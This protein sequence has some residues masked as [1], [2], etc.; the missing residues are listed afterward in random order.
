MRKAGIKMRR[1]KC[2]FFEEKIEHFGHVVNEQ[3][4]RPNSK[5]ADAIRTA[6][7]PVD[8]QLLE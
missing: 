6:F 7:A 8:K 4:V 1:N 2:K 5:K 3:G